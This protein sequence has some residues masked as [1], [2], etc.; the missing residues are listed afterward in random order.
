MLHK[1]RNLRLHDNTLRSAVV[2]SCW[3]LAPPA[4]HDSSV[5]ARCSGEPLGHPACFDTAVSGGQMTSYTATN[6]LKAESVA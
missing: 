3:R 6:W 5:H 2:C 4:L 1:A